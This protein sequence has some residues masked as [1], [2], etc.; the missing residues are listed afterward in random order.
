MGN[1]CC[2][3]EESKNEVNATE[4]G[5]VFKSGFKNLPITNFPTKE[6]SIKTNKLLRAE[7]KNE[8]APGTD[9]AVKAEKMNSIGDRVKMVLDSLPNFNIPSYTKAQNK[10]SSEIAFLGPYLYNDKSTYEGQYLHGERHGVGVVIWQD[11]SIYKGEFKND[12]C[13]GKGI[14]V[15]TEGDAYQGEWNEDK[16]HGFGY[17]IDSK[18]TSYE[19]DWKMDAQHGYGIETW[20][21]GRTYKGNFFASEKHGFGS[22]EWEDG[23]KYKGNFKHNKLHGKGKR[24]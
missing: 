10:N 4:S 16:A 18:G 9:K 7:E 5:E 3:N 6:I 20:A 14:L 19:G 2:N 13:H 21:N 17:Y 12:K 15:H 8:H 1:C 23:S 22:F 11:G 24:S